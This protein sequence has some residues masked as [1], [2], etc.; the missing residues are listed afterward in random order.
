MPSQNPSDPANPS[1]MNIH[2]RLLSSGGGM[3]RIRRFQLP[4]NHTSES[5]NWVSGD[6]EGGFGHDQQC[7]S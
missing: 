2:P 6:E 7:T 3:T 5:E 4:I 1:Q